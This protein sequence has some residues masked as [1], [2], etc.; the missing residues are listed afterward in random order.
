ME[1]A[2]AT[3]VAVKYRRPVRSLGGPSAIEVP[4]VIGLNLKKAKETLEAAK[5]KVGATKTGFDED[6]W[7]YTVIKQEPMID[8]R[9]PAL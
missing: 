6:K 7:P 2:R 9:G 5:L 4:K 3:D 1:V 8:Y